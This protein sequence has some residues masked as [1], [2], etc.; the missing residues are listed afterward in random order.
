VGV[1]C[2]RGHLG[3]SVAASST[4]AEVDRALDARIAEQGRRHRGP[5]PRDRGCG[6]EADVGREGQVGDRRH[7][8]AAEAPRGHRQGPQEAANALVALQGDTRARLAAEGQRVAAQAG[9]ARFLAASSV[10]TPR[11]SSG[12][13]SSWWFY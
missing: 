6:R 13:W 10:P 5:G 12:G 11:L 4:V 7:G 2:R 8:G 1:Y 3:A 9:R